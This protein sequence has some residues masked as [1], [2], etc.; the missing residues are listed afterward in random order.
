MTENE[1]YSRIIG[2]IDKTIQNYLDVAEEQNIKLTRNDIIEMVTIRL[3]ELLKINSDN[4][5]RTW[6]VSGIA[7]GIA[8]VFRIDEKLKTIE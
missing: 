1:N 6:V 3:E 8:I 5:E 7:I 4:K 2:D